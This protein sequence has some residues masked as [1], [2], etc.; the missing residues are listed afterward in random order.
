MHGLRCDGEGS[1]GFEILAGH[2]KLPILNPQYSC[3]AQKKSEC[4]QSRPETARKQVLR[5]AYLTHL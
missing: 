5:L 3:H 1:K 2:I 4:L